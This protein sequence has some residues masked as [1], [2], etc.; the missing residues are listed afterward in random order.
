MDRP[1]TQKFLPPYFKYPVFAFCGFELL[2]SACVLAISEA[3]YRKGTIILPISYDMFQD[4]LRKE[5]PN[6][7]WTDTM[8]SQLE[9]YRF[10]LMVLW[11]ISAIGVTISMLYVIPQFFDYNDKR[12]NRSQLCLVRRRLGWI[13][14]FIMAAYVT[15]F[16]LAII[17]A[18]CGCRSSYQ[19]FHEKF[20]ACQKE[21]QYLDQIEKGFKCVNDDDRERCYFQAQSSFLNPL[22]MDAILIAYF[23]GHALVILLIPVLNKQLIKDDDEDSLYG[24]KE[25]EKESLE[26]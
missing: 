21:E 10:K 1:F 17:W 6:F 8:R 2:L 4:T 23:L 7:E 20:E 3:Y 19:L 12:G 16:G 11:A 25:E 5:V 22:W 14:F 13:L 26:A 24:V 15:I 9:L 18:W